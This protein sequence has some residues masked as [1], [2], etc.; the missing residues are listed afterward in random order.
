MITDDRFIDYNVPSRVQDFLDRINEQA[1]FTR[2]GKNIM[3]TMGS[4]FQYESAREWYENLDALMAAVNADGRIT[5]Q[6]STPSLYVQAKN[7][8]NNTY[9]VKTDDFFRQ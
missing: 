6:Y 8:E 5:M 2:G 4:D 7:L 1:S 9:T 3:V